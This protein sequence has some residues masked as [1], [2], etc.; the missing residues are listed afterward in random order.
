MERT[1]TNI[2]YSKKNLKKY[3]N[4]KI[5]YFLL[6]TNFRFGYLTRGYNKKE[7]FFMKHFCCYISLSNKMN[8]IISIVRRI[9]VA[10]L[11]YSFL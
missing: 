3:K 9:A 10:I 6:E 4:N 2:G 8:A 11:F 1:T 5:I 7:D